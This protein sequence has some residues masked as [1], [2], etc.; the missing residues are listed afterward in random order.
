MLRAVQRTAV[1]AALTIAAIGAQPVS[2]AR[3]PVERSCGALRGT[4]VTEIL[5]TVVPCR[6]A[7]RIA[8][9]HATSVKRG[10]SCKTRR[11]GCNIGKFRCLYAFK[12]DDP[13]RVLCAWR[14]DQKVI[15]VYRGA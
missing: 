10:G 14:G 12:P 2:A 3:M 15:L 7:R 11:I 6:E 5:A 1:A 4:A 8:R 9:T 13:H